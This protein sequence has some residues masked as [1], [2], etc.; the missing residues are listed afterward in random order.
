MFGERTAELLLRA[1]YAE[2]GEAEIKTLPRKIILLPFI[3]VSTVVLHCG[4]LG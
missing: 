1:I 3:S 4:S 2:E